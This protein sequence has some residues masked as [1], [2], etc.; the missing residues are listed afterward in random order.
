MDADEPSRPQ[1]PKGRGLRIALGAVLILV[2]VGSLGYVLIEGPALPLTVMLIVIAT[3]TAAVFAAYFVP[4]KLSPRAKRAFTVGVAAVGVI[5][6]LLAPRI[7][8]DNQGDG[9]DASQ[10]PTS[11]SPSVTD[12]PRAAAAPLTA[13]LSLGGDC[14]NFV[15]PAEA[16]SAVPTG[17]DLNAQWI[18]DH[19]GATI[20]KELGLA[21]QGTSDSPV[22]IEYLRV[23]H[24]KAKTPPSKLADLLPCG[25]PRL[26]VVPKRYLEIGLS[27]P[28]QVVSSPAPEADPQTGETEPAASFPFQVSKK[29]AEYFLLIVNGPACF[30]EWQLELGWSSSGRTGKMVLDHGFGKIRSDTSVDPNRPAHSRKSDGTWKPPLPK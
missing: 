6:T 21:V 14:E 8:A 17:S 22:F 30:C 23:I 11:Q 25:R 27:D 26:H 28:P 16:L 13:V 24:L 2:F 3:A 15:M 19:G 9:N 1:T 12:L 5:T 29:Q 10:S 18:Y 7:N 20:T 4:N